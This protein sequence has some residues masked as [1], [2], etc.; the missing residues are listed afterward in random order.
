MG[1]F[2]FVVAHPDDEILGAGAFIHKKAK[3]GNEIYG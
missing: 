1:R 2:L 3:E